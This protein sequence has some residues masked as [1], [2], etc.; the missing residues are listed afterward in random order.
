MTTTRPG[1]H[2]EAEI[3]FLSQK[4]GGRISPPR[5]GYRPQMEIGG[6][7]TSCIFESSEV[8]TF[9]AGKI[10]LLSGTLLF[11]DHYLHRL[12]SGDPVVLK[13][14]SRRVA[15]GRIVRMLA[16]PSTRP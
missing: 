1:P 4:D 9:E 12:S 6:E 2:F 10:Y 14:G 3:S 7:S 15:E 13:E 8:E 11:P 5:S 16:E